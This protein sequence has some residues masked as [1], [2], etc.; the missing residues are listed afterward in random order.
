MTGANP[1]G[2]NRFGA[3]LTM[4][5][6]RC[7]SIQNDYDPQVPTSCDVVARLA[8]GEQDCSTCSGARKCCQRT[9]QSKAEMAVSAAKSASNNAAMRQGAPGVGVNAG[10]GNRGAGSGGGQHARRAF[11][12]MNRGPVGYGGGNSDAYGNSGGYSHA[13]VFIH[14]NG[15]LEVVS[16]LGG[17]GGV[18]VDRKRKQDSD[19]QQGR[20]VASMVAPDA[21]RQRAQVPRNAVQEERTDR[22]ATDDM[23]RTVADLEAKLA[24][25]KEQMARSAQQQVAPVT[26]QPVVTPVIQQPVVTPVIQQPIVRPVI[27]QPVV[28]PGVGLPQ[29]AQPPVARTA[30]VD[31]VVEDPGR[32]KDGEDQPEEQGVNQNPAGPMQ[33]DGDRAEEEPI[34]VSYHQGEDRPGEPEA[35]E[36]LDEWDQGIR[37]G[38]EDLAVRSAPPAVNQWT[39]AQPLANRFAANQQRRTLPPTGPGVNRRVAAPAG[40]GRGNGQGASRQRL[41]FD[42]TEAQA[43]RARG[44]PP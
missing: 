12:P 39:N 9:A 19:S 17:L 22:I 13:S 32:G 21:S 27:Q 44:A 24:E 3:P 38:Q 2:V 37:E 23:A 10:G 28:R 16:G 31:P 7:T 33:V 26:Q 43:R 1:G 34:D 41:N 18:P 8:N 35:D 42:Q 36:E 11:A 4:T 5:C 20:L 14:P 29:V 6:K 25:M 40:R 15:L 30:A